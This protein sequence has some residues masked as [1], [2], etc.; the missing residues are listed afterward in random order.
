M[1]PFRVEV[2]RGTFMIIAEAVTFVNTFLKKAADFSLWAP[3]TFCEK[4]LTRGRLFDK[5]RAT[6]IFKVSMQTTSDHPLRGLRPYGQ[7]GQLPIGNAVA[8]L[9]ELKAQIL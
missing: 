6:W 2:S 3:E 1:L 5:I 7:P 4:C 9:I 8:L